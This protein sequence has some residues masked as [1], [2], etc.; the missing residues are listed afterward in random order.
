MKFD[1]SQTDPTEVENLRD[2]FVAGR[3]AAHDAPPAPGEP[4]DPEET[5]VITPRARASDESSPDDKPDDASSGESADAADESGD[6][7]QAHTAASDADEA[8]GAHAAPDIADS[9]GAEQD[10]AVSD[11]TAADAPDAAAGSGLSN[12]VIPAPRDGA[13]AAVDRQGSGAENDEPVRKFGEDT[14]PLPVGNLWHG[15]MPPPR[16][17]P[18][19]APPPSAA[20]PDRDPPLLGGAKSSG[21]L[22]DQLKAVD[23][24]STPG[25]TSPREFASDFAPPAPDPSRAPRP[26]YG[27]P[28]RPAGAP[29]AAFEA[30]QPQFGPPESTTSTPP[31]WQPPPGAGRAYAPGGEHRPTGQPPRGRPPQVLP[32]DAG[33][34]GAAAADPRSF[35]VPPRRHSPPDTPYPP[36]GAPHDVAPEYGYAARPEQRPGVQPAVAPPRRPY[37]P[38]A[39]SQARFDEERSL[40]TTER[41][42]AVKGGR[43]E[44]PQQGWRSVISRMG[45]PLGKGAAEIAY[46]HDIA[47][48]NKRL[49]Y[50]KTIGVVAFKGGV[51]KTSITICLGSTLATHRQDG[52]VVAVDTV[53]RGTLA[54]RV[55]EDH[56]DV[57]GDVRSLAYD[58]EADEANI[59]AVHAHLLSNRDRL[60]VLGS[61]RDL[62]AEP[63]APNEYL[64]A[65]ER[66]R[67]HHKLVLVDTEPSTATPAFET[68][69]ESLDAL[70]LVVTPTRD[71]AVPASEVLPWLR[72]R[73]LTELASRTIVL[74]NHQSPAKPHMDEESITHG[75]HKNEKVEV[76]KIPYDAHLAEA[77]PISLELLDKN[78]RRQFVRAAAILLD[79]LPAN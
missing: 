67:R 8:P 48:I 37:Q 29:S 60:S 50:R 40:H 5:V 25:P 31:L 26:D 62:I 6:T 28:P 21:L 12:G 47:M 65:L 1:S 11:P 9:A 76:L 36:V 72:A 18:V 79:K 27:P 14:G 63:L 69:M 38:P 13:H 32:A 23:D 3:A 22:G 77:S 59:D 51:G 58:P 4:G 24:T 44:G 35:A 15:S 78:T 39:E 56:R 41:E 71:G 16:D 66:L 20:P 45:I 75:F 10:D 49:R 55:K 52:G 57:S 70:I 46:D 30:Q 74:L 2:K 64:T 19:A 73:G 34:P 68:I 42:F 7:A 61:R 53:A 17:V 43:R 33:R 54:M